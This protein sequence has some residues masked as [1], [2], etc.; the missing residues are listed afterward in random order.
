MAITVAAGTGSD[1]P[2]VGIWAVSSAGTGEQSWDISGDQAGSVAGEAHV[3]GS[4][5]H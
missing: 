3:E 2:P 4:W 1:S 5:C